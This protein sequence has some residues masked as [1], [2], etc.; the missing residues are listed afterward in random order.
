MSAVHGCPPIAKVACD[1]AQREKPCAIAPV[2]KLRACALAAI[3]G[4]ASG[5]SPGMMSCP[6]FQRRRLPLLGPRIGRRDAPQLERRRPQSEAE[7]DARGLGR[8]MRSDVSADRGS[9]GRTDRRHPARIALRGVLRR[10]VHRVGIAGGDERERAERVDPRDR[11]FV[12]DAAQMGRHPV[13]ERG[14]DAVA[15]LDVI[16]MDGNAAIR[17][18][19]HRPQ[20]SS[21]LRCR[22]P[23]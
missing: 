4:N 23:W 8:R 5:G 3:A 15:H 11:D 19:F 18:D 21:P 9:R 14:P 20:R 17:V 22:N 13:G 6:S 2:T 12:G 16:A 1:Q 10:L 7:H